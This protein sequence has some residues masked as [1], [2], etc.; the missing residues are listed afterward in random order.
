MQRLEKVL[1][2]QG[3]GSRKEVKRLIK[4]G[5]VRING[6]EVPAN[7]LINTTDIVSIDGEKVEIISNIYLMMNKKAGEVCAKTDNIYSTVYERLEEKL[8]EKRV[9][10]RLNTAGRL[11]IDTEGLL[12]FTTDGALLHRIISPNRECEK[13]YYVEVDK[14]F[15]K[16][17][18]ERVKELFSS[19]QRVPAYKGEKEFTA[20]PSKVEFLTTNTLNLTIKEGKYH[21]VKRM[22]LLVGAEVTYLKRIRIGGL[23]LDDNLKVGEYR[24][25]T[26]Y[27]I[28]A[29]E[30]MEGEEEGEEEDTC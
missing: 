10:E 18:Q 25:L 24:T 28:E 14:S 15:S 12:L 20:C 13:V 5:R 4:E 27:E 29:I 16:E 19:P 22:L 30:R 2:L 26:S 17:E 11:D 9:L 6:M 23:T 21:Q 1:S 8:R 7:H 3:F